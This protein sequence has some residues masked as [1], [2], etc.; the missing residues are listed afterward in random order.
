MA[1]VEVEQEYLE[2]LEYIFSVHGNDYE[3]E[4]YEV[5]DICNT[6]GTLYIKKMKSGVCFWGIMDYDDN[7]LWKPISSDLYKMIKEQQV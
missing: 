1:K 2:H 7:I 3:V 6:Y 5:K 4:K